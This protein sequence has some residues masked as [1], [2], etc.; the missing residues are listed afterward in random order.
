MQ[1]HT[2]YQVIDLHMDP[3]A[4]NGGSTT[5]DA[6]FEATPMITMPGNHMGNRFG[7]TALRSI[8]LNEEGV[9][10]SSRKEYEDLAVSLVR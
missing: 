6:L 3:A 5:L 10:I 4:V 1:F 9:I 7:A 8:G 2:L